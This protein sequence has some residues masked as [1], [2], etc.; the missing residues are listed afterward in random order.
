[1]RAC[2]ISKVWLYSSKRK[3]FSSCQPIFLMN[4]SRHPH[5][6]QGNSSKKWTMCRWRSKMVRSRTS[7]RSWILQLTKQCTHYI[8]AGATAPT[9]WTNAVAIAGE[10]PADTHIPKFHPKAADVSLILG[11]NF[12][13]S[14]AYIGL[15]VIDNN[16]GWAYQFSH[17]Y[18]RSP[19]RK[20]TLTH[21]RMTVI[22]R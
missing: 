21:W 3:L 22:R 4:F 5:P 19:L 8:T 12:S 11:G 2:F 16:I 20:Y 7:I 14:Q 10:K 18:N 6:N 17:W 15:R 9:P 13:G 1:M